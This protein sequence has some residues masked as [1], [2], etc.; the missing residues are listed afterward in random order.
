MQVQ[1]ADA[2]ESHPDP[3]THR[4]PLLRARGRWYFHRTGGTYKGGSFK[5]IDLTFGDGEAYGG[6]LIRGLE[7]PD[8]TLVDGPSLCVDHLLAACG[9]ASVAA[10]DATI[11]DRLAWDPGN[12]LQLQDTPLAP[13]PLLRTARIGLALRRSKPAPEAPQYVLRPIVSSA[14]RDGSP[15]ARPTPCS[16][17]TPTAPPRR[18]SRRSPVAPSLPSPGT[19]PTSRPDAA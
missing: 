3:F 15:R 8:G 14:S 1:E 5:G 16:R 11:A 18:R 19:S 17:C 9:V 10:L 12:L 4:D 13:G 7:R 6:V 2:T